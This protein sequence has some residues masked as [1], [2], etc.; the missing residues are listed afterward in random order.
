MR[1]DWTLTYIISGDGKLRAWKGAFL[2]RSSVRVGVAERLGTFYG[3]RQVHMI[4][5]QSRS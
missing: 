5:L 2:S 1:S 3:M 4:G